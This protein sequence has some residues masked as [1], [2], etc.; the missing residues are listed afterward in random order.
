MIV[1][2]DPKD[3][4]YQGDCAMQFHEYRTIRNQLLAAPKDHPDQVERIMDEKLKQMS[5][6]QVRRSWIDD[7]IQ[8][9][10]NKQIGTDLAM[11]ALGEDL[12]VDEQRPYYNMWPIAVELSR[13]VKLTLPFNSIAI[14]F[15]AML[16]RFAK[17]HEP[18]GIPVAM[19]CWPTDTG[20][21]QVAAYSRQQRHRISLAYHYDPNDQVE[22][23]L[24][25]AVAN[26]ERRNPTGDGSV[27]ES[28]NKVLADGDVSASI[29]D[30]GTAVP[31]LLIRLCV[32]IGLL[33]NDCDFI[34]PIV[35]AKD[36]QKHES[37]DDPDTKKWLEDRAARRAGR[38]FDVAMKLQIEKEKSPHWRNPH[39][40]LF[41]T[42]EE[43]KKPVI[44]LRSGAVVQRVS[45]AEVPTGYLGPETEADNVVPSIRTPRESISKTR[46]FQ[47]LKRDNYRCQLCGKSADDAVKLHVDH[48]L[49]V[50][51]GGSNEDDNLWTLCEQ[52]NLGKSDESL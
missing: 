40:C 11:T 6:A 36:R 19:L 49:A 28:L 7:A 17:G 29:Y 31:E 24:N 27:S 34:T 50:A 10:S 14:P 48:R 33:A 45:M 44:Q 9:S 25:K 32:F 26:G 47:I 46:R 22:E 51:K 20:L 2:A 16:L 39:L 8:V 42:G 15:H 43:R 21:I 12:W 37:T 23:W 30:A 13:N 35:L 18:C 1:K 4:R 41:W 3:L 5:S 38:G 52:C